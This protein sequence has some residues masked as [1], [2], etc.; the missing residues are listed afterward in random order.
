MP[1]MPDPGGEVVLGVDTHELEHVAAVI[2]ALGRLLGARS[3]PATAHGFR[4]L[5]A[6]ARDHGPLSRAG[7]EGTG[8]FGAGLAR[9]LAAECVDVVEV[10]RPNRRGRRHLGKSDTVDAEEAA[11]MVLSGKRQRR[12]SSATV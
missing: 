9:F 10:T 7:V 12:R 2:D 1:T 8:S 4:E 11:R 5:L 3:F 6:W